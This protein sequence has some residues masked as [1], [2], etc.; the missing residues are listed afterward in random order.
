M[1]PPMAPC[2][3]RFHPLPPICN[4]RM[5]QVRKVTGCVSRLQ[6]PTWGTALEVPHHHRRGM[7]ACTT[8][9]PIGLMGGMAWRCFEGACYRTAFFSPFV[10]KLV[11]LVPVE[12]LK[13]PSG[14]QKSIEMCCP[15]TSKVDYRFRKREPPA[16]GHQ[17][18]KQAKSERDQTQDHSRAA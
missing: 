18:W 16:A 1:L 4:A 12:T 15:A 10:S 11:S 6:H 8:F 5:L 3:A 7:P 17:T 9:T 2:A 13:R 14:T